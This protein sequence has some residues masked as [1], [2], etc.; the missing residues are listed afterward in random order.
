MKVFYSINVH[1]RVWFHFCLASSCDIMNE[2]FFVTVLISNMIK[3]PSNVTFMTLDYIYCSV[4]L[5]SI[6]STIKVGLIGNNCPSRRDPRIKVMIYILVEFRNKNNQYE[7]MY[8]HMLNWGH[9]I[10]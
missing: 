4:M 7:V 9:G 10:I 8:T 5:A 1:I 3:L 2:V 6:M